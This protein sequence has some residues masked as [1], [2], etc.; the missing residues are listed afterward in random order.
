M[1]EWGLKI[2]MRKQQ[3]V[4]GVMSLALG[5]LLYTLFSYLYIFFN[6]YLYLYLYIYSNQIN[7][8]DDWK[9]LESPKSKR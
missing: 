8:D 5:Y 4:D 1:A 6:L 9:E 2:E 7:D 3:R